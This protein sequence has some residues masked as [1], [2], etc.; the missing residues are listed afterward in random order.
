MTYLADSPSVLL[1]RPRFFNQKGVANNYQYAEYNSLSTKNDEQEMPLV[2]PETPRK[3][4]SGIFVRQNLIHDK[5]NIQVQRKSNTIDIES[6]LESDTVIP[7]TPEKLSPTA[8]L[9]T[10]HEILSDNIELPKLHHRKTLAET[11]GSITG[12]IRQLKRHL[13]NNCFD[14]CNKVAKL[15]ESPKAR[16]SLFSV[17]S[18]Y[19]QTTKMDS[20]KNFISGYSKNDIKLEAKKRSSI[21]KKPSKKK[22]QINMGVMHKIRKPKPKNLKQTT[23][24]LL[25]AALNIDQDVLN[26]SFASTMNSEIVL[27]GAQRLNSS[28]S[29]C[30]EKKP[31]KEFSISLA[32]T[33][34]DNSNEENEQNKPQRKFF[35][36]KRILDNKQ[37]KLQDN[38]IINIKSKTSDENSNRNI[39][40]HSSDFKDSDGMFFTIILLNIAL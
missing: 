18:F 30:I 12:K 31:V 20:N 25:K 5:E 15:D 27:N 38:L 2:D 7:E 40:V 34:N 13:S 36:S 39:S 6:L 16:T 11:E 35:K 8:Q 17:K 9:R 33:E 21:R 1:A 24:A 26:T 22:G 19:S 3:S 28:F 32:I 14:V 4:F 10:P 37:V 23:T 29:S